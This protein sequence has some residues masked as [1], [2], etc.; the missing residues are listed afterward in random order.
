M[1]NPDAL[2]YI[3]GIIMPIVISALKRPDWSRTAKIALA[4]I[5]SIVAG[6]FSAW[7]SNDLVF[8]G[9]RAMANAAV[10]FAEASTVYTMLLEKTGLEK[11]LRGSEQ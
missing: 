2:A 4:V 5:V 9:N 3:L 11:V 10:V 7:V 8:S 6:F 1:N